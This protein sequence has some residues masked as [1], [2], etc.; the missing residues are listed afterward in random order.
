MRIIGYIDHPTLKITLFKTGNRYSMK[1]ES[2]LYEQTYKFREGEGVEGVNDLRELI[3]PPFIEA[4][5][6]EIQRMHR[7]RAQAIARRQDNT[8]EEAFDEII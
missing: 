7:L 6:A 3:D 8:D 1:F 5:A 4:V 2:G